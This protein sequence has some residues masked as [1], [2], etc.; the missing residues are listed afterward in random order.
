MI[1]GTLLRHCSCRPAPAVPACRLK[2]S[3][4][5][6]QHVDDVIHIGPLK[7]SMCS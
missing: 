5:P 7:K 2:G 1:R 3:L 4:G 6:F